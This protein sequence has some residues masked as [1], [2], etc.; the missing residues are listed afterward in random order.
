MKNLKIYFNEEKDIINYDEYYFNGI[1]T[2]KNIEI[3]DI[4]SDSFKIFWKIDNL[5]IINIDN[6]QIKYKVE[7]RKDNKNE[8]FMKVYEGK[9]LNCLIDN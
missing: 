1:Q 9:N 2:P 3:K 6:N 8:K 5:N 7:I 4:Y